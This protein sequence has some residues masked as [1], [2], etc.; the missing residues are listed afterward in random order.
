M[1][2]LSLKKLELKAKNKGIKGYKSMSI[3]KL[4]SILDQSEQVKK[5]KLSEKLEK[6]FLIMIK[7]LKA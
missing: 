6:K 2:S 7:R 1:L 4:L 3:Y 5:L